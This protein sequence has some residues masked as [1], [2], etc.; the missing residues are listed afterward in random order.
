MSPKPPLRIVNHLGPKIAA[1]LAAHPS[2]PEVITSDKPTAAWGLPEG[3]EAVITVPHYWK[4]M[5]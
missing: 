3:T 1:L 2:A 5:P 4:A